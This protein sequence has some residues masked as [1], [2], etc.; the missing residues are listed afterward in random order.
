MRKATAI[1]ALMIPGLALAACSSGPGTVHPA[2][3]QTTTTTSPAEAVASAATQYTSDLAT[4]SAANS[5]YNGTFS[6]VSA[7]ISQQ[8]QR[9]TQD[10]TTE[11]NDEAGGGCTVSYTDPSS[12]PACVSSEEQTAE[13][14]RTDA[15]AALN[16]LN[17][18]YSQY[19]SAADTYASALSTFIGQVVGLNWP[20]K[21]NEAVNAVV[22]TARTFRNDLADESAVTDSTPQ[23]TV[24]AINAQSQMDIGTFNDALNAL[25]AEL[26]QAALT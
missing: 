7:D 1:A 12:F 19:A 22:T 21:Y 6:Q 18:D 14:A 16:Q 13:N 23:S 15:N 3:V 8:E 10:S 26:P 9:I 17:Q 20:S 5:T 2:A 25:K 4:E 24:S 11:T